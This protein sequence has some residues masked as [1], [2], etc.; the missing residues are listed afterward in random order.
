MPRRRSGGASG[1]PRHVSQVRA[2][3]VQVRALRAKLS[4]LKEKTLR[5][6]RVPTMLRATGLAGARVRHDEA[7]DEVRLLSDELTQLEVRCAVSWRRGEGARVVGGWQ[8]EQEGERAAGAGVALGEVFFF[9]RGES[10]T[11]AAN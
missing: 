8:Q 1:V 3:A 10:G 7:L 4:H 11:A 5:E 9:L 6:Q 2:H